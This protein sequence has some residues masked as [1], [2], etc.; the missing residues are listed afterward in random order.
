MWFPEKRKRTLLIGTKIRQRYQISAIVRGST[1]SECLGNDRSLRNA[2]DQVPTRGSEAPCSPSSFQTLPPPS[3]RPLTFERCCTAFCPTPRAKD[4]A[5]TLS[6]TRAPALSINVHSGLAL[7]CALFNLICKTPLRSSSTALLIRMKTSYAAFALPFMAVVQAATQTV[8]VGGGLVSF[9]SSPVLMADIHPE[10]HQSCRWRRCQVSTPYRCHSHQLHLG[11]RHPQ[12][13][14]I[15]LLQPVQPSQP[16][17]LHGRSVFRLGT[18]LRRFHGSTTQADLQFS[19]T[20]NDTNPVWVWC[21]V[22]NH[23]SQG[24][25][26]AINA[27]DS[28]LQSFANF[29][30]AAQG[31]ALVT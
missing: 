22:S 28:A 24:M 29:Q 5:F 26:M 3:S 10:Q 12:R 31:Q 8:N 16:G 25:V 11:R 15:L 7:E 1:R 6:G 20:I 18:S 19:L 13:F 30:R 23:C 17:V 21:D 9:P 2:S 14:A 4:A 27:N